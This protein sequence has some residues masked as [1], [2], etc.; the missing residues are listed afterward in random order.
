MEFLVYSVVPYALAKQLEM[1]AR[2]SIFPKH[3]HFW[4]TKSPEQKVYR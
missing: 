3:M 1:I 4:L 2:R